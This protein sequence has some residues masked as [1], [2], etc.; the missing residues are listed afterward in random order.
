MTC[1]ET[2]HGEADLNAERKGYWESSGHA[3]PRH[4]YDQ[5][6][7]APING[8]PHLFMFSQTSNQGHCKDYLSQGNAIAAVPLEGDPIWTFSKSWDGQTRGWDFNKPTE[9][10]PVSNLIVTTKSRRIFWYD[11]NADEVVA[12]IYVEH[13]PLRPSANLVYFPATDTFYLF[14]GSRTAYTDGTSVWRIWEIKPNRADLK[15]TT[16]EEIFPTGYGPFAS[17][18][19][20]VDTINNAIGAYR[21]GVWHTL[22]P[23]E[24]RWVAH[25]MPQNLGRVSD[26]AGQFYAEAG[27]YLLH[28]G[29]E[30]TPQYTGFAWKPD[31]DAEPIPLKPEAE[32]AQEGAD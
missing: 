29:S 13:M 9:Y 3:T 15:L 7:V 21:D 19:I 12:N 28:T 23:Q 16:V 31:L 22:Y 20:A 14:D 11:Q 30:G 10:D 18:V 8:V 17:R 5:N 2:T 6:P 26:H 4:S 25:Q 27:V 1:E 24:R 32:L